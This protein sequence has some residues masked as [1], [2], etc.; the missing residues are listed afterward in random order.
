MQRAILCLAAVFPLI[1]LSTPKSL[2]ADEATD[3]FQRGY[4]LAIKADWDKAIEEFTQVLRFL[5]DDTGAYVNR[6]I[7]WRSKGELDKAIVDYNQA[8]RLDVKLPAAYTNRG[9]VWELKGE[10]DRAIAD[11]DQAIRL[12]P[13]VALA[14]YNR[15]RF[16]RGRGEYDKA[17]T[18]CNEALRLKP[19]I[20]EVYILRGVVWETKRDYDKA[21]ADY[22]LVIHLKPDHAGAHRTLAW[23]QATCPDQRYRHGKKSVANA[24]RAIAL[25]GDT[26]WLCSG[27]LAAAYAEDGQFDKAVEWQTKAIE[28]AT[29]GKSATDKD[30]EELRSRRE[31]YKQGQ[32]YH[33]EPKRQ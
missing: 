23:F 18:D 28:L 6:G 29:T 16:W 25:S 2:G 12:D 20:A 31:L 26:T 17:I 14:Y 13:T 19:D 27:T 3:H 7:A 33:E 5:P 9:I 1:C 11:Y 22:N 10:Y 24:S 8:I 4:D 30:K 15:G 21:T 32:P